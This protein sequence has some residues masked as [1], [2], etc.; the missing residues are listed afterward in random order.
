MLISRDPFA[1]T[2]LHRR[3]EYVECATCA[4]CGHVHRTPKSRGYLNRYRIETDAGRSH[5]I[6]RLFCSKACMETYHG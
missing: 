3:R 6:P 1:R 5:E 4:W 2:E